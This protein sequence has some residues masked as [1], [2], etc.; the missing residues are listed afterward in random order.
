MEEIRAKGIQEN[1]ELK[2][3]VEGRIRQLE[4]QK[5]DGE[6]YSSAVSKAWSAFTKVCRSTG[7]KEDL[8]A[9]VKTCHDEMFRLGDELGDLLR[10]KDGALDKNQET[11]AP[12][13]LKKEFDRQLRE[14]EQ[15][16]E[17]LG[18]E[19]PEDAKPCKKQLD[20]ELKKIASP[21]KEDFEKVKTAVEEVGKA[22]TDRDNERKLLPARSISWANNASQR[23]RSSAR[24]TRNSNRS[25]T[26]WTWRSRTSC[27][28]PTV[29]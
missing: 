28:W 23:P 14:L 25:W 7:K 27:R 1:D 21:T 5:G 16:I 9:A 10:N 26:S 13:L 3:S 29:R 15:L 22:K 6:A 2:A 20:E 24:T 17:G 18:G 12:K 4:E 8:E 11:A 19:F